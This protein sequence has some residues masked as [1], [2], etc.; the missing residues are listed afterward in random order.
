MAAGHSARLSA[1]SPPRATCGPRASGAAG[2]IEPGA[3][4]FDALCA[5]DWA[6]GVCPV[7]GLSHREVLYAFPPA[8]L[9]RAMVEKA[10][11]DRALC[12][13]V[14]PVA[15][16]AP[17]W[18]KLLY[19]SALPLVAL[20]LEGFVRFRSPARHLLHAGYHAPVELAVFACDFN[21]LEPRPGLPA[22]SDC[23]GAVAQRPHTACGGAADLRYRLRLREA[24]LA[25][26]GVRGD[27]GAD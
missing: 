2:F 9:V 8:S 26:R 27:G 6:Q 12:V 19:A 13:L 16:L 17:Y 20:F 21:R 10:C 3:E 22:L 4:L 1:P 24:L 11:A 15:I 7:C 23:S 18:R 14:V 5:P 25:H